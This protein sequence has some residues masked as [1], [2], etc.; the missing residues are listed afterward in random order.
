MEVLLLMKKKDVVVKIHNVKN[1]L[2]NYIFKLILNN[3]NI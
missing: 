2:V 1:R 3:L